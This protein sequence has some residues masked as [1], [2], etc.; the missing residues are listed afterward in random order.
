MMTLKTIRK[1]C[2]AKRGVEEDFP[3]DFTTLVFKV[4]GKMFALT[5]ITPGTVSINLKCE[6]ALA[7]LLR[8][9]YAAV[10]PGY[11]MNKKHWNTVAVDGTIPDGEIR[12]MIDHSYDLVLKGLPKALREKIGKGGG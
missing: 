3:F 11:H 6:P 10:T 8:S 4:G 9:R 2:A 1:Y 12:M 7:E 5:D